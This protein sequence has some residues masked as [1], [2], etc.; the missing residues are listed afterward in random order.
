MVVQVSGW[1]CRLVGQVRA[2]IG[3]VMKHSFYLRYDYSG[4]Y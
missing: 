1:W 2:H 4:T 3:D